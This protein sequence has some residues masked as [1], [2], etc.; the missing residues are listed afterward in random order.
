MTPAIRDVL[1]RLRRVAEF[2]AEKDR[3][4]DALWYDLQLAVDLAFNAADT[5][6][7]D[8]EARETGSPCP[9]DPRCMERIGDAYPGRRCQRRKGHEGAHDGGEPSL[10]PGVAEVVAFD[11]LVRAP[12]PPTDAEFEEAMNEFKQTYAGCLNVSWRYPGEEAARQRLRDL[13][14]RA[15]GNPKEDV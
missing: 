15:R 7:L 9:T 3:D 10:G 13:L 6:A 4:G 5:A 2:Y 12:A 1:S 11:K 14:Q 8:A